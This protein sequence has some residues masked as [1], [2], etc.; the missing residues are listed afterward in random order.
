MKPRPDAALAAKSAA[1]AAKA[2][3][4]QGLDARQAFRR[5]TTPR[6]LQASA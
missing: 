3:R 6:G 2:R 1:R 4:R 5:F